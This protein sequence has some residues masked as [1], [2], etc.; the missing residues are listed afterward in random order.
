MI[1]FN[2]VPVYYIDSS[3]FDDEYEGLDWESYR[4]FI[5]FSFKE[6]NMY[7]KSKFFVYTYDDDTFEMVECVDPRLIL[8]TKELPSI[9]W[10]DFLKK[11]FE[12]DWE[13]NY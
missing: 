9:M 10:K 3:D 4:L 6:I 13:R 5:P 2:P 1:G 7:S 8:Y 11:I 12:S